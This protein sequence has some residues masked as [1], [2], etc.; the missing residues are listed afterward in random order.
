MVGLMKGSDLTVPAGEECVGA[1]VSVWKVGSLSSIL[2]INK[3]SRRLKPSDHFWLS[4][5]IL[6]SDEA[7]ADLLLSDTGLTFLS[8]DDL[9]LEV[10]SSFSTSLAFF[11]KE[12]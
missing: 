7:L 3:A 11:Q 9:A 12:H 10:V 5:A 1:T 2:A 8:E 6:A 4:S